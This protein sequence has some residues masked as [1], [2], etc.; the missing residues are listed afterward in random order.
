M[1][2]KHNDII[3]EQ[4]RAREEFLKLKKMQQGELEPEAKPSEIALKPVTFKEKLQ[5]YWYHFKFQTIFVVLLAGV[6]AILVNQCA[7]REKFDFSVLYFTY[8]PAMDS[9]LDS[10]EKY[11]ENFA[12]DVD[13]DGEVNIQI[14]NCSVSEDNR[15]AGRNTMFT[16]VQAVLI[17]NPEV[18]LYM[19]D[20]KAI[21]YFDNAFDTDLFVEEPIMLTKDFY[22]SID[23]ENS[24][25]EGLKLGVRVIDDTA[26][27]KNKTAI[28]TFEESKRVYE[29]I[30]ER[31]G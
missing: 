22:K 11:F 13:G 1:S 9:Q 15:D 17:A 5:N 21:E 24:L 30:K 12:T 26:L 16:K 6:M 7:T 2:E 4:R 14:I 3:E 27:E 28:K 8:T 25:P 19:V 31:N 23:I 20:D 10:A 29:K 18:V